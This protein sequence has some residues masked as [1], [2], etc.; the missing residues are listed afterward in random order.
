M[1]FLHTDNDNKWN[2]DKDKQEYQDYDW[3]IMRMIVNIMRM[4]IK[5]I[6]MMMEEEEVDNGNK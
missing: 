5:K 4:M 6:L 1:I 2:D 3:L